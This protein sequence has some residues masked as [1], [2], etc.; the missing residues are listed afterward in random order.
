MDCGLAAAPAVRRRSA[1]SLPMCPGDGVG[2]D[3][4]PRR[5]LRPDGGAL[6]TKGIRATG[7]GTYL[8]EA[9]LVPAPEA[10]RQ[11]A[12]AAAGALTPLRRVA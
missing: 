6:L 3:D 1:L 9:G 7:P 8:A 5:L 10:I 4:R 2:I 12:S 11:Q